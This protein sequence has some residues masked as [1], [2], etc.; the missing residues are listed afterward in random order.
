MAERWSLEGTVL[1]ACNC[2]SAACPCNWGGDA[3]EDHCEGAIVYRVERGNHG[4]T[5]LD[6]LHVG[7]IFLAAEKNFYAGGA[8]K[9]A[10]LVD[11]KATSQQRQAM[12]QILGG[13]AG[14]LFG[15]LATMVKQNAGITYAP[16]QYAN[17]GKTWSAKA[18]KHLEI[19]SS[20][21]K[22]PQGM[23]LEAVPKK[24]Q[25]Y[26]PFY[27]PTMEKVAGLSEQFTVDVGGLK[28]NF[29]GRNSTSGR[30][31]LTGPE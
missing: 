9:V 16:F 31:K 12:E 28:Y 11:D 21:A 18:G 25:T 22:P 17:D 2:N 30:F 6:G 8:A 5:K 23:P 10:W 27:A 14:G 24:V 19:R 20:F 3:T 4:S 26:D 13:K 29:Q 15:M 1:D 7:G